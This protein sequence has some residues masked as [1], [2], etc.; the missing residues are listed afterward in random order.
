MRGTWFKVFEQINSEIYEKNEFQYYSRER[1]YIKL[2][3]STAEFIVLIYEMIDQFYRMFV[4]IRK[5]R[6]KKLG[7]SVRNT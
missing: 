2:K 7:C 3:S 6:K 1:N 5:Q 4:R